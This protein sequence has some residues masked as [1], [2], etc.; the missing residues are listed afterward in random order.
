MKTT[1]I[2]LTVLVAF[3]VPSFADEKKPLKGADKQTTLIKEKQT[4]RAAQQQFE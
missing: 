2:T 4:V 3:A 1:I